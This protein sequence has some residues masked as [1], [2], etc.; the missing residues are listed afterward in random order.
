MKSLCNRI[1]GYII[2]IFLMPQLGLAARYGVERTLNNIESSLLQKL[3]PI[4]A[5]IGLICAGIS[6]AMGNQ[7]ARAHLTFAIFGAIIGFLAPHLV[8]FI[9]G[10][11][12]P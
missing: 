8:D 3:L 5:S 10:M 4:L 2:A 12:V 6:F 1:N 7:N 11:V 9:R